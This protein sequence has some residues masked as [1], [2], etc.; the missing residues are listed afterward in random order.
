VLFGCFVLEQQLRGG[1]VVVRL[2]VELA[3]A[4]LRAG[5]E[6]VFLVSCL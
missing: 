6:V 2:G 4:Q 5:L 3:V 1:D